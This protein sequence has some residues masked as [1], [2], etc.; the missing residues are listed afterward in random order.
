MGG[1]AKRLG[2]IFEVCVACKI[3][4]RRVLMGLNIVLFVIQMFIV[5]NSNSFTLSIYY[6]ITIEVL[7]L[8]AREI[9][10]S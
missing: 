3:E 10:N 9:V 8:F 1:I 5:Y 7:L 6:F 2:K 4:D